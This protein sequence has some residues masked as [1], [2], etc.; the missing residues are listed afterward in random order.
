MLELP[1]TTKSTASQNLNP[2]PLANLPATRL[3]DVTDLKQYAYCRRIPFYRYCLPRIRPI[4]YGMREGIRSHEEESAR[5]ERRSLRTYGL[6]S[7]ERVFDLVLRSDTLGLVA[8]LDLAIRCTDPSTSQTEAIVVEYKLTRDPAREH[9]R[10]QLAAYA[11]LL[12]NAWQLPVRRAFLYHIPLR[13]AEEI[14]ITTTLRRRALQAIQAIQT[15]VC[16]ERMPPSPTNRA[17]CVTCEF[18]RFCNDAI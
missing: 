10:L 17:R 5:E 6:T 11:L 1:Q 18:R 15:M 14:P 3:L 13:R 4:T 2:E 8:R 7:G 9:F 12:E 16:D